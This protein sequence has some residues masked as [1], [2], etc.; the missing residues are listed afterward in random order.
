MQC[1]QFLFSLPLFPQRHSDLFPIPTYSSRIPT[2]LFERGSPLR[3]VAL[4]QVNIYLAYNLTY[5]LLLAPAVTPRRRR[6]GQPPH[7]P[8]R[9]PSRPHLSL[10][11]FLPSLFPKRQRAP[12]ASPRAFLASV[13]IRKYPSRPAVSRAGFLAGETIPSTT[14]S[15]TPSSSEKE[16]VHA[17]SLLEAGLL[18]HAHQQDQGPGALR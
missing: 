10:P 17:W 13:F 4:C 9:P 3:L 14:P 8:S 15:T 12:D 16:E 5:L 6:K 7:L 11:S 2:Y 1:S 18:P